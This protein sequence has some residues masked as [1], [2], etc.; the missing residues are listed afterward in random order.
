MRNKRSA[1]SCFC[2]YLALKEACNRLPNPKADLQAA[3][4][5]S[6]LRT[7]SLPPPPPATSRPIA[8]AAVAALAPLTTALLRAF[9]CQTLVSISPRSSSRPVPATTA[10]H[11]APSFRP[12]LCEAPCPSW[13]LRLEAKHPLASAAAAACHHYRRTSSGLQ[14]IAPAAPTLLCSARVGALLLLG[15]RS[16]VAA[17]HPAPAA[18]RTKRNPQLQHDIARSHLLSTLQM[19]GSARMWVLIE[20]Q[21][22]PDNCASPPS[23]ADQLPQHWLHCG[24]LCIIFAT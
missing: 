6:C 11:P 8:A 14:A 5:E 23:R 9:H 16:S 1:V 3:L 24:A 21:V 19:R 13:L 7:A 17:A 12:P 15:S 18:Q 10:V 4:A 20:P 2:S 22:R